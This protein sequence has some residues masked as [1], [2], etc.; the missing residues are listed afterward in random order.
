MSVVRLR[1]IDYRGSYGYGAVVL[2]FRGRT[3]T[4]TD[5]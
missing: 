1:E 4:A 5:E 3:L 2:R